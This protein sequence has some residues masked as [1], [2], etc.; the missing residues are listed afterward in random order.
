MAES[1]LTDTQIESLI[2]LWRA[3][4]CLCQ[5]TNSDFMDVDVRRIALQK[6]SALMGGNKL[7]CFQIHPG[8]VSETVLRID[9][10]HTL[11]CRQFPEQGIRCS[12]VGPTFE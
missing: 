2:E 1:R 11:A 10:S 12:Q 3:E 7:L 8:V 6:I 5:T 9:I 4:E